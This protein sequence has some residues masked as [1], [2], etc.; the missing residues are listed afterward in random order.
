MTSQFAEV[1]ALLQTKLYQPPVQVGL[2][3]RPRL[4]DQLNAH[5]RDRPLTLISAP[6]GYG[7]SVLASM[8]L[9]SINSPSC[10]VSLDERDNDLRV[11]SAYL[12]AAVNKAFPDISLRSQTLLETANPLSAHMLAGYL[13]N[14]LDQVKQPF[15]LVLDD[16]HLIHEQ[17]V[18]ELLSELLKHPPRATHLVLISRQDP[19][20]P[21]AS[22][23]AYR[24]ITEIRL[25]DL[26]F[27]PAE[28]AQLLEH[29][30]NRAVDDEIA[31][32]WTQKTEGWVTALH[33]AALSFSYQQETANL[34]TSV[35]GDSQYLREYL[36]TEVLTHIPPD[37]QK[38]LIRTS[39]L[40]RFCIPLCEIVCQ[41]EGESL[42]GQVFV[43]WLQTSN[44]FLIPLDERGEWFRFHL[45]PFL[46][47]PDKTGG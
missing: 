11:F 41:E 32:A 15:I 31:S 2:V 46:N 18:I 34:G 13:L 33:L 3:P 45:V 28:T 23:R 37:K 7:K 29:I 27:T 19:P 25:S 30:L 42:T 24:L 8:W 38:W 44:L 5:W 1:S 36:L 14:D 9:K 40:D 16:I 4:F 47:S 22:L 35:Q 26:R 17:S 21:I 43:S 6:A 12:L 20:I 10:W 39:L